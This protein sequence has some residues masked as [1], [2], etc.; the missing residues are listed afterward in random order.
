MTKTVSLSS[1]SAVED[2]VLAEDDASLSPLEF[3]QP[4]RSM[5]SAG[6][7]VFN[8]AMLS[9]AVFEVSARWIGEMM[10]EVSSR[11]EQA[12]TLSRFDASAVAMLAHFMSY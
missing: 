10:V 2:A 6:G 7:V 12:G 9:E 3:G 11:C 8:D 4:E 5:G 1:R